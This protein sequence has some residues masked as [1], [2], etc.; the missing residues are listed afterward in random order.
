MKKI[1]LTLGLSLAFLSNYAHAQSVLQLGYPAHAGSGCPAGTASASLT[2]DGSAL[3]L[4]FDQYVAQAGGD[5][6]LAMDRKNCNISIPV[7]VPEGFSVSI[8]TVDY[9]GFVSIPFGGSARFSA[10]YF[11]AGSRG[12]IAARDFLSG[13]EGDFTITNN[14]GIQAMV[15]SAC[16]ADVNLRVNT[17]MLVRTNRLREEAMAVVDSADFQTGIVFHLKFKRC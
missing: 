11:F 6:R 8:L 12:P 13:S 3:T 10:E 2:P 9:R 15:W 17:N 4:L 14:L 16:G 7:L 1:L 5:T